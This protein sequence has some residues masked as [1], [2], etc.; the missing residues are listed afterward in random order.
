MKRIK[1]AILAWISLIILGGCAPFVSFKHPN[2]GDGR[3]AA[4]A[5]YGGALGRAVTGL[6]SYPVGPVAGTAIGAG[7]G[8]L[9]GRYFNSEPYWLARLQKQRVQVVQTG[10]RVRIIVPSDEL[11][12][13]NSANLL[14]S[15]DTVLNDVVA[16]IDH[17]GSLRH[18]KIQ[19]FTD[20]VQTVLANL[21]LSQ[22]QAKTVAAYFWSK[23]F[24]MRTMQPMG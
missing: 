9:T 20:N 17:Y 12:Y 23:G 16:F 4:A 10:D 22:S 24:P 5:A 7:V 3:T 21:K 8:V 6:A 11:F 14:P 13:F 1:L 19:A 18:I 2:A 15:G